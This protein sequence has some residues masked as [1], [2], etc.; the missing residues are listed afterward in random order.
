MRPAGEVVRI[1]QGLAVIRAPGTDRPEIG[2]TLVDEDLA[3]V[4]RV[5]DVFGPVQRPY[6]ALSPAD[7]TAL[8]SLLG[9]RLYERTDG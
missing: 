4:G 7:G 1:A 2:A 8:P 5:V 9:S 6:V 3:T